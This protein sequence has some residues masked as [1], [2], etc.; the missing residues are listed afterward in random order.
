MQGKFT[1][2]STVTALDV[3][4][5]NASPTSYGIKSFSPGIAIAGTTNSGHGV[6][7]IANSA[8]GVGIYGYSSNGTGGL[9][10]TGNIT[11][12]ALKSD[13]KFWCT[14]DTKKSEHKTGKDNRNET[15]AIEG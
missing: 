3:Q 15:A 5:D 8:N 1:A 7:G 2:N 14:A 10:Q 4:N 11:T 13:G 12:F 6:D 9:F